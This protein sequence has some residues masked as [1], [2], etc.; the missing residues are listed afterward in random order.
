[1]KYEVAKQLKDAGFSQELA[2]GS[3]Y[4]VK[5]PN[6]FAGGP[7]YN[8]FCWGGEGEDKPY[9]EYLLDPALSE[10][11]EVCGTAFV[12]LD[13]FDKGWKATGVFNDLLLRDGSTPEEA[14][15]NLWLALNNTGTLPA[16]R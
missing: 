9:R 8:R 11:I 5:S 16:A 12:G 15:A 1:M 10:L 6:L 13:R 14:V 3:F 4:L 2:E 7:I